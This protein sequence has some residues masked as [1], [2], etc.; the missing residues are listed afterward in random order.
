MAEGPELASQLYREDLRVTASDQERIQE[1]YVFLEHL[2][3]V[4]NDI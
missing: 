2:D 3:Q 1:A 4:H